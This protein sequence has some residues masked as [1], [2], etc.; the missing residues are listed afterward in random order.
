MLRPVAK[1]RTDVTHECARLATLRQERSRRP[2]RVR[3]VRSNAIGLTRLPNSQY[4][5][6]PRRDI[7]QLAIAVVS[8]EWSVASCQ[9]SVLSGIR[10]G[11][12]PIFA[13]RTAQKLGQSPGSAGCAKIGTVPD[14]L[15]R[16]FDALAM[17]PMARID[18]V[19]REGKS[20]FRHLSQ[21]PTIGLSRGEN[22]GDRRKIDQMQAAPFFDRPVVRV[23]EDERLD[24]LK[25]SQELHELGRIPDAAPRLPSAGGS[26]CGL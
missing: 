10:R 21:D 9:W 6:H 7:R 3:R 17:L 14:G 4:A 5:L 1:G 20:T 25:A 12:S 26:N 18:R 15:P 22:V 11:N 8:G 23:P 16:E 2:N 24:V 19:Q 13:P